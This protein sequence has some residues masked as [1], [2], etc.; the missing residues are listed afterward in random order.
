MNKIVFLLAL[1]LLVFNNLLA[2]DSLIINIPSQIL[3]PSSRLLLRTEEAYVALPSDDSL[4]KITLPIER[5][6]T[7]VG[8]SSL[9][10][11]N[12]LIHLSPILW[13]ENNQVHFIKTNTGYTLE[14]S[15]PSQNIWHQLQNISGKKQIKLIKKHLHYYPAIYALYRIQDDLHTRELRE[16]YNKIPESKRQYHY[17]RCI[18]TKLKSSSYSTVKKGRRMPD[19]K[20]PDST[21]KLQSI[22]QQDDT[23]Q[24][25]AYLG[26]GCFFSL[27]S[28]NQLRHLYDLHHSR[29]MITTI[30]A[31]K[32][33]N[34][35]QH[36]RENK[37]API[38]WS[39]LWD[40]TELFNKIVD[41]KAFPTYI[42]INKEG[43][44][45]KK[46]HNYKPKK[47]ERQVQKLLN[48]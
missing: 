37:K 10:K 8:L 19:I 38:C 42:L 46:W 12:K 32:T 25:I 18:A 7:F 15:H 27:A 36:A 45:V 40:E 28:I 16:L 43:E 29:L 11:K 33:Y 14:K 26:T 20:L 23:P 5:I 2:Q 1:G 48:L 41:I 4:I 44:V 34:T 35:W 9:N 13:T 39:D 21:M 30:W 3:P 31:D 47:L 6:P 22:I 17:A 24:L